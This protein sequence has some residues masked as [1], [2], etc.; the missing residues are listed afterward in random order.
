MSCFNHI[1]RSDCVYILLCTVSQRG[2]VGFTYGSGIASSYTSISPCLITEQETI[3]MQRCG[4]LLA[5]SLI[6][7][8]DRG[9]CRFVVEIPLLGFCY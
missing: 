8:F 3:T 9:R 5:L 1:T 7:S 2:T 4:P 6:K